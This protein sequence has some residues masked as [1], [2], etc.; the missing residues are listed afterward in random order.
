MTSHDFKIQCQRSLSFGFALGA[1]VGWLPGHHL[2]S[3]LETRIQKGL[4]F[5][6]VL[7]G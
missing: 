6:S 1:G 5:I 3:M 4:L 2:V 7:Y